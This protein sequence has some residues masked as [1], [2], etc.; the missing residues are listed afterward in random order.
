M[1]RSH[2]P[3]SASA[4]YSSQ[5]EIRDINTQVST[6]ACL[7]QAKGSFGTVLN[8]NEIVFFMGSPSDQP[9]NFDIYNTAFGNWSIG[10]LNQG[11]SYPAIISA[12][13][14]IYVAGGALNP[15]GALSNQV[16]LLEW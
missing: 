6:F 5:V 16:A 4:H 13:N 2:S 7:S 14:K 8:G 12:N 3:T 11:L 10:V 9:T 1:R 15:G